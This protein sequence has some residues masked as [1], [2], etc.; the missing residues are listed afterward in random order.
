MNRYALIGVY[1]NGEVVVV[2]IGRRSGPDSFIRDEIEHSA[3]Y[4]SSPY[5]T[6]LLISIGN[7]EDVS[8]ARL[9]LDFQEVD[10]HP[11]PTYTLSPA[12]KRR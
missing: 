4:Q 12:E 8:G 1:A 5:R 2:K 6:L 9:L 10:I 11:P 3:S 7:A